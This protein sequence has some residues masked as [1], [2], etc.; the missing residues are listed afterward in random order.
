[1]AK[2]TRER[3]SATAAGE[4]EPPSRKQPKHLDESTVRAIR[5]AYRPGVRLRPLEERFGLGSGSIISVA[6][7]CTYTQY[8]TDDGEY[9]PPAGIRGTRRREEA[10]AERPKQEP[11]PIERT[12]MKHLSP[13]AIQAIREAIDNGEPIRRIARCFGL[14]PEAIA[15]MKPH[16]GGETP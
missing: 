4:P 2:R 9:E 13:E 8:P 7:R 15:H 3:R 12:D 1:M 11:P 6:N 16:R 10:V 14:A 5:R